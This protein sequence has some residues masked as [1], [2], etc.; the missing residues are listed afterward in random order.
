RA[1]SLSAEHASKRAPRSSMRKRNVKGVMTGRGAEMSSMSRMPLGAPRL[2]SDSIRAFSAA[3]SEIAVIATRSAKMETFERGSV[4]SALIPKS[5]AAA[6]PSGTGWSAASSMS[7]TWPSPATA[8]SFA[9][10]PSRSVAVGTRPISGMPSPLRRTS[11]VKSGA[12]RAAGSATA[13]ASITR[14]GSTTVPAAVSARKRSASDGAVPASVICSPSASTSAQSCPVAATAP[15]TPSADRRSTKPAATIAA[16]RLS[17][18]ARRRKPGSISRTGR[19]AGKLIVRGSG[20]GKRMGQRALAV[21]GPPLHKGADGPDQSEEGG[22]GK[23]QRSEQP[24]IAVGAEEPQAVRRIVDVEPV[25]LPE[26]MPAHCPGR[27]EGEAELQR[28]GHGQERH[29]HGQRHQA[30]GGHEESGEPPARR[31][32]E[33]PR[34]GLHPDQHVVLLVLMSIDRVVEERPGDAGGVEKHCRP[35]HPP[36]MGGRGEDGAPVERQPEKELRPP[37]KALGI[38]VDR[39][40]AERGKPER[41]RQ[42]VVGQED[43]PGGCHLRRHPDHRLPDAD[44]PRR[45]RPRPGAYHGSVEVAVGDVVP[46]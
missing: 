2:R 19:V 5:S 42:P 36:G 26:E 12:F 15:A 13:I 17:R 20:R 3:L 1:R 39:Y 37:G 22:G 6:Q 33:E 31:R 41:D 24:G 29:Q 44:L 14:S 35:V 25:H 16:K 30:D 34:G 11:P 40:Q 9:A 27:Q 32:T 7:V 4:A 23:K 28:A 46:G 43:E 8:A 21:G 45:D 18:A 38:G 10:R